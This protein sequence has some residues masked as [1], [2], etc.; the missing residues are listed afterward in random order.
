MKSCEGEWGGLARDPLNRR[1]M[2]SPLPSSARP[3]RLPSPSQ[4]PL[5]GDDRPGG[6]AASRRGH[7]TA[8]VEGRA[9]EG[10][11]ASGL[12]DRRRQGLSGGGGRGY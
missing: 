7:A 6:R 3:D 11:G 4:P 12:A 2:R 9:R 8:R 5:A 1:T 10:R